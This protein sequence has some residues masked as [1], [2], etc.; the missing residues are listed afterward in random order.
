[1]LWRAQVAAACACDFGRRLRRAE[2]Q[3]GR[4]AAAGGD[5]GEAGQAHRGR[6]RRICRPF[7][8]GRIRSR[9][10]RGCPAISTRC[11]SRTARWSSRATCCSP[12]TS[13]RSRTR[14]IRRAPIWRGA[15]PISP[16]PKPISTRGQQLVRDKTITEQTFEQRTQAIPQRRRPRSPRNEAAVRQAELDLRIHRVA[17]AGDGPHRRPPR[18]AGQSRHRRHRRQHHAARHHR[19]DRSDPFRVH[20]RRS[21]LSALRAARRER[22]GGRPA[23]T[24]ASGR[25]SS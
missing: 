24:P 25:R 16:S 5:G 22:Q 2:Q 23:A 9:C 19:L 17:R 6:L 7:R 4:A 12:S 11:I 3:A 18:V 20:L 21:L 10:A 15:S 8:R 13:G 1:M 14:S